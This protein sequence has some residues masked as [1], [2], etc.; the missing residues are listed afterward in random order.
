MR[1]I[2]DDKYHALTLVELSPA[3]NGLFADP[4]VASRQRAA[5]VVD[6]P[7]CAHRMAGF[8]CDGG[9]TQR[10]KLGRVDAIDETVDEHDRLR[11]KADFERG[12]S[13]RRWPSEV[14]QWTPKEAVYE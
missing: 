3:Q 1:F 12:P 2:F 11:P 13:L 4:V 10:L 7:I 6:I 8:G 14:A 9:P 5:L